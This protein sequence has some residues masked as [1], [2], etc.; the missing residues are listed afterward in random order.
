MLLQPVRKIQNNSY[1]DKTILFEG[2]C[3]CFHCW[4][5]LIAYFR[6]FPVSIVA[7]SFLDLVHIVDCAVNFKCTLQMC[8]VNNIN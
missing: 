5:F 4:A 6:H 1:R 8:E 7:L 2:V 3:V